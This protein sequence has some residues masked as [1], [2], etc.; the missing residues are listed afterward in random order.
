MSVTRTALNP[1][2]RR[3]SRSSVPNGLIAL[4]IDQDRSAG[5]VSG[6][7]AAASVNDQVTFAASALPAASFT[8][9]SVAPPRRRRVVGRLGERQ[10]RL[11]PHG[12]VQRVVGHRRRNQ[13]VPPAQLEGRAGHRGC[14]HAFVE[15]RGHRRRQRR[16]SSAPLAGVRLLAVGGVMSTGTES[17]NTTS[18][19]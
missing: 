18:T 1:S 4:P 3:I 6:C 8:R 17:S 16:R 12:A 19:Q 9:G 2:V 5:P 15:R 7:G 10:R 13:R 11:Q 14:R